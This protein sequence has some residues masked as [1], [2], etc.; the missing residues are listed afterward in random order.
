MTSQTQTDDNGFRVFALDD[1]EIIE[2][3][4]LAFYYIDGAFQRT[5]FA[6]LPAKTIWDTYAPTEA[7]FDRARR[8]NPDRK[9]I[10]KWIHR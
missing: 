1:L 6:R 8:A 9:N 3:A 7:D 2:V 5:G 4:G 10:S